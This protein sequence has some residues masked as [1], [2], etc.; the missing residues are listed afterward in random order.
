M[1]I[2]PEPIPVS[3]RRTRMWVWIGGVLLGLGAALV[4][5]AILWDWNWLRPM[6]EVRASAGIGR[7]VTMER[8]EVRPGRR[9]VITAHGM[10]VANP[11]GFEGADF[12]IFPSL[13]VTFDLETWLRTGRVLLPLVEADRPIFN[14]LETGTGK[15]NWV[16]PLPALA[17]GAAN[18]P[19]PIEVGDVV[20]NGG[21][22]HVLAAPTKA[23][24]TLSISTGQ[25]ADRRTLSID[26]KGTYANQP[27]TIHA[28][29][30]GLL[31]L[32]DANTPYPVDFTL[33]NGETHIRMTG[34]IQ[35][36]LALTGADLRLVLAGPDMALL[37]PL[38]GIPLPKTPPYQVA[39]KLDFA[40]GRIEFS[41][42]TGHVG[43]TDL[44]GALEV[45]PRGT[46]M[47]LTGTLFSHLVDL[48]D[49]AGF[50]GS[51]PGRVT[52]PGLTPG[53]IH[54]IT[55]AKANPRL[56]P[57][58]P[59]SITKIR[60]A[61][62]HI[63]YR[64][65]K[66]LGKNMPFDSLAAT[67]TVK[68]GTIRLSPLRLGLGAGALNG[69]INLQPVGEELD[70]DVDLK[71]E[72]VD[73]GKL[74]SAAGLGGGLGPID[75]SIKLKGRGA[76]V[77]SI[78]GHSNGFVRLFMPLGGEVNALLVDLS[79]IE[80]GRAF[81]ALIGIPDK[82]GIL[83]MSADFVL[84]QGVLATRTLAVNTTGH[85]ITGGGQIDLNR[86]RLALRLRT[87][88]KHFSVGTIAAPILISGTFKDLSFAPDAELALRGGAAVGLGFLFPP[89][90]VLPLI[91]F[92][93]GDDSPCGEPR[94]PG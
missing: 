39:G 16:L 85:I 49:L 45:D 69:T 8:L 55:L 13:S 73:V 66:V 37:F 29:G 92:G 23:D 14:V 51:E 1:P 30:G 56:L 15:N 48:E 7:Q 17:G 80:L 11:S 36:P 4:L 46:R 28:A 83:C 72:K 91:Q 71:M 3:A 42:I 87:Q 26:G 81:F 93:V 82:E 74:L 25:Q 33:A 2:A 60:A 19:P 34:S 84:T 94:K 18:V 32:Q 68:D 24:M 44:N 47:M 78:A 62:A 22:S 35:N 79:G 20:I 65:D 61:D 12:A 86:E 67:V 89:A 27:I 70:A 58:T 40:D 38:T 76:S 77:S 6:L 31:T 5:L 75:G 90:A 9:T 54:D 64:S 21:V 10:H 52:T 53:Q 43:S 57:T 59:V 41:N 63:V 50:I 88:A